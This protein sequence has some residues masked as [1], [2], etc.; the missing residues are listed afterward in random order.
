MKKSP[1]I[2]SGR[3]TFGKDAG[4]DDWEGLGVIIAGYSSCACS[5]SVAPDTAVTAESTAESLLALRDLTSHSR[6]QLGC[7]V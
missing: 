4:V 2:I 7:C 1:E 6:E 5:K 3:M